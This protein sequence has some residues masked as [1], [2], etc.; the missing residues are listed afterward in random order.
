MNNNSCCYGRASTGIHWAGAAVLS[1][2]CAAQPFAL[3]PAPP[4]GCSAGLGQRLLSSRNRASKAAGPVA[5]SPGFAW[6]DSL[7]PTPGNCVPVPGF[8]AHQRETSPQQHCLPAQ[9]LR[10][11]GGGSGS[12]TLGRAGTA[13]PQPQALTTVLR[14]TIHRPPAPCPSSPEVGTAPAPP[15]LPPLPAPLALPI[16]VLHPPSHPPILHHPPPMPPF[17]PWQ[18]HLAPG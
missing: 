2:P 13:G 16:R 14:S 11:D 3:A 1:L 4:G 6:S 17:I 12:A 18:H 8:T 5:S 15:L 9:G 10:Q 7:L